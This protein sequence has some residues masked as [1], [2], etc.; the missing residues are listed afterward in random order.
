[1]GSVAQG[2]QQAGEGGGLHVVCDVVQ[3]RTKALLLWCRLLSACLRW[4]RASGRTKRTTR[5]T[6]IDINDDTIVDDDLV[7]LAAAH[8]RYCT[9]LYRMHRGAR[10]CE[11]FEGFKE[12]TVARVTI[13][14][15]RRH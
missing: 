11:G 13:K 2:Q 6:V 1:M 10:G 7:R 4:D 14:Y 9:V 8:T 3:T 15:Q 5:Q 12:S